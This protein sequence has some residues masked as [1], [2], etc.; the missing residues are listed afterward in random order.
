VLYT[1][2]HTVGDLVGLLDGLRVNQ[3]IIVGHDWGANVAWNAAMM[4][5][6]RFKAVF[7]LAVPYSPRGK[8][9]V[10]DAMKSAGHG[11][12][13]YMFEQIR[14][15]ADQIWADAAVTIPGMLYW[16]SGSAPADEAWSPFD[17]ARSLHRAPPAHLPAWIDGDYLAHNIAEFQRT[18]FHG[19]LNYYRAVQPFFD[20]SGAYL[21]ATIPQPAYFI[22]GEADG[23]V[24]IYQLTEAK[25]RDRCPGL[26]GYVGLD[27]VGHWVQHEAADRVN[28]DLIAF[29]RSVAGA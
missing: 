11:A 25:L 27:G 2:F 23:L 9:S 20:L 14:P 29:A 5:P 28:R 18:G 26:A 6:D 13:F 3:A 16:A 7:C 12:D 8:A 10:L 19:A 17:P 1:P 24:S 21:G 4:R 22:W 15:E